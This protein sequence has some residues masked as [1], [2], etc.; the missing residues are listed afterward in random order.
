M[1]DCADTPRHCLAASL[2]RRVPTWKV[3]GWIDELDLPLDDDARRALRDLAADAS[4]HDEL[5][6]DFHMVDDA[7]DQL[8]TYAVLFAHLA[9]RH[10][11][12]MV[13][14]DPLALTRLVTLAMDD[15]GFSFPSG[16]GEVLGRLTPQRPAIS[17]ALRKRLRFLS[18]LQ[19]KGAAHR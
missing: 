1:S 3:A 14:D 15:L 11:Q 6:D 7:S 9:Q 4:W 19:D 13:A 16:P 2:R 10:G 5:N 18:R 17:G 12:F 8:A